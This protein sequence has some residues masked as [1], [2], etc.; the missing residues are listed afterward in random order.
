MLMP[1]STVHYTLH[2]L[3]KGHFLSS[4]NVD[5]TTIFIACYQVQVKIQIASKNKSLF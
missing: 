4:N 5:K 3:F 1:M 2:A